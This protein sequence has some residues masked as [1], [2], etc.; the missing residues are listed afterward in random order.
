[1]AGRDPK[2][3]E[4][5]YIQFNG[6]YDLE[7]EHGAK[8]TVYPNTIGEVVYSL[9]QYTYMTK[10]SH[11]YQ[12]ELSNDIIVTALHTHIE[13]LSEEEIHHYQ[14]IVRVLFSFTAKAF[15][16]NASVPSIKILP[17][18][19][20]KIT[21]FLTFNDKRYPAFIKNGRFYS[22]PYDVFIT[23]GDLR[24]LTRDLSEIGQINYG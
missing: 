23:I 21:N 1:M 11:E 8:V 14:E 5:H 7:D 20:L 24:E 17:G 22:I 19:E 15:N 10:A 4:G 13:A 3:R 6:C 2:I 12:I 18:T 16:V 9:E